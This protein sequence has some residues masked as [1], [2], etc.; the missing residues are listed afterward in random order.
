[1]DRRDRR[2]CRRARDHL[3]AIDG[4]VLDAPRV[5]ALAAEGLVERSG[6]RLKATGSGRLV[7]DRLIL[8]LAA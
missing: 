6:D 2:G 1:V 7:L 8:E 5:E 4:R 3:E